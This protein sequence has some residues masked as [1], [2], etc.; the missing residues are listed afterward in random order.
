MMVDTDELLSQAYLQKETWKRALIKNPLTEPYE[1]K[2]REGKKNLLTH[3]L[4]VTCSG[5][6][7][8]NDGGQRRVGEQGRRAANRIEPRPQV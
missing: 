7:A 6:D 4:C 3:L 5:D 8:A 1:E 2:L